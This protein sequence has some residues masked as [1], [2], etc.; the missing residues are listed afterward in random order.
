MTA[1][2]QARARDV[3]VGLR[4]GDDVDRV[5]RIQRGAADG[6]GVAGRDGVAHCPREPLP[7]RRAG[8][9]LPLSWIVSSDTQLGPG[10]AI[11]DET[12]RT[13]LWPGARLTRQPVTASQ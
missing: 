9:L 5:D 12:R 4:R 6:D 11:R 1:G 2:G 3:P 7:R 10:F 13:R 8:T